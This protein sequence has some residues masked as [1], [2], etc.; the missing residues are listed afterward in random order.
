LF[1]TCARLHCLDKSLALL[2]FGGLDHPEE[3]YKNPLTKLEN[4]AITEN[5]TGDDTGQ[6]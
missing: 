2:A 5:D 6:E 3:F 4:D 1:A